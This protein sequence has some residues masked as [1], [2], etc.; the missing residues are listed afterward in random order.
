MLPLPSFEY[1]APTDVSE[2]C[3]LLAESDTRLVAGGT[4]LLV[5]M[6]HRLFEPRRLVSTRR[7]ELLRGVDVSDGSVSI[8]A[9]TTLRALADHPV[10]AAGL[11]ALAAACRTVATSTIQRM[12][13]IGG[14]LMLDTR[15]MYY[16][17][18]AGWRASLGYC[19]KREGTVCHVAPKGRGCYAVHAADTV[20]AL[21]LL[22]AEAEFVTATGV[23]RVRVS[24]MYRDDGM[25]WLELPP[26]AILTRVHVPLDASRVTHRK[27]RTRQ[28]IDYAQVLVA[29]AAPHAPGSPWRAV[30]SSVSSRPVAVEADSA[31]GV[32]DA[33]LKAA[34]PL[35]T[36]LAPAT[37]RK[38]MVR[39]EVLRAA[40]TLEPGAGS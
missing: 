7:L 11:P 20:P 14:N 36:H 19:L 33:A 13:T 3:R 12:G 2:A 39:V 8:G 15:C 5:S 24:D 18:P 38:K 25:R 10:V 17:Q 21:W 32:A 22:G 29:V 16:N 4:D 26:E 23:R 1:V 40:R 27:L 30:V 37:W 31:E 9:S 35:S 34:Q 6:K 28:A